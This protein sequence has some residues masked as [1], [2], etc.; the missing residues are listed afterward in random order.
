MN[1][2]LHSLPLILVANA[3]GSHEASHLHHHLSDP[4]WMP[5]AAGL[6]VIGCAALMAWSSK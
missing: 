4:N 3:A 2:I 5:L 1:R 6:L